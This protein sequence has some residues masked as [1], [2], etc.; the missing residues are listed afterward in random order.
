MEKLIESFYNT[1]YV[2][3]TA[4]LITIFIVPASEWQ[5][6]ALTITG[7]NVLCGIIARLIYYRGRLGFGHINCVPE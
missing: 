6:I 2:F 4:V 5:V 1:S 3:F 7:M